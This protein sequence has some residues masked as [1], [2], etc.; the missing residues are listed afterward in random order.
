MAETVAGP[1][2]NV[3]ELHE[4][5]ISACGFSFVKDQEAKVA[6]FRRFSPEAVQKSSLSICTGWTQPLRDSSDFLRNFPES[7]TRPDRQER[8]FWLLGTQ[9]G[10]QGPE[11]DSPAANLARANALH[12]ECKRSGLRTP[13]RK[14]D[15]LIQTYGVSKRLRT[16]R[17][18]PEL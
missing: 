16:W 18:S 1:P 2:A 15:R 11:P 4:D 8:T 5:R 7:V 6:I 17:L 14:I 9:R 12:R 13:Q 3:H 10:S